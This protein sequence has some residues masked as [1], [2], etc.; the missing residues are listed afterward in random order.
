MFKRLNQALINVASDKTYNMIL[1]VLMAIMIISI[2][3]GSDILFIIGIILALV[4][5]VLIIKAYR[6]V[7]K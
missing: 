6:K 4:E 2:L 3:I 1:I 7:S 5:I